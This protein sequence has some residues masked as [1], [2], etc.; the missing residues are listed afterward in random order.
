MKKL[1][2]SSLPKTW[3]LDIDGTLMV[4]NGHLADNETL[5]EGVKE[6]FGS[7]GRE[8]KV[9]LLTSRGLECRDRLEKF[10]K[11]QHIPFDHIIYDMPYGERILVNDKKPSGLKTAY[12]INKK[13]NARLDMAFEVD[14][15][16]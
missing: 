11:R 8:D 13:R 14:E 5:L 16:L 10:L 1:R 12:A 2:L 6:F 15:S 3:L 4:H 7:I 9:I